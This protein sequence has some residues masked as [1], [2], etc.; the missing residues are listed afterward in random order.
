MGNF[1]AQLNRSWQE[2][3]SCFFILFSEAHQFFIEITL[4]ASGFQIGPKKLDCRKKNSQEYL[5]K[6]FSS[7]NNAQK[8]LRTTGTHQ[9]RWE[10]QGE[11]N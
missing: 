5:K 11:K 8:P 2:K 10:C 4:L 3:K 1:K 9:S 6:I 7:N